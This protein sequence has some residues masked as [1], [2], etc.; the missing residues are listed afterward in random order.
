MTSAEVAASK[1][2][3]RSIQKGDM[4]VETNSHLPLLIGPNYPRY[5]ATGGVSSLNRKLRYST[6]TV[7]VEDVISR[8]GKLG[9][10]NTLL[11]AGKIY[12]IISDDQANSGA[13]SS[14]P[15]PPG[16]LAN[17]EHE[18]IV[19]NGVDKVFE[20]SSIRIYAISKSA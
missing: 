14:R 7:T 5:L 1:W 19:G 4:V 13:R 11:S 16:V 2:L 6:S 10:S 9:A 15:L 8:A 17:F 3:D 12:V 20:D 18:L